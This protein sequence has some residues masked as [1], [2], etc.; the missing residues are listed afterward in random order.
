LI[1]VVSQAWSLDAE[2][3]AEAYIAGSRDFEEFLGRHPGYIGRRLL[4]S[5]ADPTH[6]T[7]MR[8]FRTIEDYHELITWDGYRDRIMALGDHLRPADT[9]PREY[10]EVVLGDEDLPGLAATV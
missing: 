9:Y 7:N 2:N 6:F 1:V 5:M 10:M 3:H 8:F 4:R